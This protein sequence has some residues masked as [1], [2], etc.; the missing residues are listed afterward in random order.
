MEISNALETSF[1]RN[2][3]IKKIIAVIFKSMERCKTEF[4][5]ICSL[6]MAIA[7]LSDI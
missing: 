3:S 4:Y 6:F 7:K 5:K 1:K 2:R